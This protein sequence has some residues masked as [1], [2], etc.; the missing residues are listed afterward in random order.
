MHLFDAVLSHCSLSYAACCEGEV[1]LEDGS[2]FNEGRVEVCVDGIWGTVCNDY[3]A[4][5]DASVVCRQLGFS[6]FGKSIAF[7]DTNNFND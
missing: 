3:F 2:V 6:R 5:I 4:S 1:R 7:V